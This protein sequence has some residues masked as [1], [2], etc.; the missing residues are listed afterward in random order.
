MD[1][2]EIKFSGGGK[3]AEFWSVLGPPTNDCISLCWLASQS[4][5]SLLD[6]IICIQKRG[7]LCS[8]NNRIVM[9]T[10]PTRWRES[11]L[12]TLL[13]K[14]S[15]I[16]IVRGNPFLCL[17]KEAIYEQ[18]DSLLCSFVVQCYYECF[19]W[20]ISTF[21]IL[22]REKLVTEHPRILCQRT[23]IFSNGLLEWVISRSASGDATFIVSDRRET[24]AVSNHL[25]TLHPRAFWD[26]SHLPCLG[27]N[28]SSTNEN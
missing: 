1:F 5:L 20:M 7:E 25:S 21:Y 8:L 17:S 15:H 26:S 9:R 23:L 2:R 22:H 24:L 19:F 27:Y 18:A 6:F 14:C 28:P 11:P 13:C 10:I 12:N 3:Y 4:N 16:N